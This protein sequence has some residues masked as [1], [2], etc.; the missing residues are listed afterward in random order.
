M[1]Y[2]LKH[3]VVQF[4]G[5]Y[6]SVWDDTQQKQNIEIPCGYMKDS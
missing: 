2:F 6:Q 5:Y 3:R 1:Q 4:I